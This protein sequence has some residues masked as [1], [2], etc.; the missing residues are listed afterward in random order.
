MADPNTPPESYTFQP[1][2]VDGKPIEVAPELATEVGAFAKTAKLSAEQAQA[3]YVRE[4]TRPK[5][6]APDAA[7]PPESYTFA[8]LKAADGKESDAP[9]D[10]VADVTAEAKAMGLTQAQAQKMLDRELKLRDE[11][12]GEVEK[13]LADLK[14]TWREAGMK[15]QVI[16]GEKFEENVSIA[17]RALKAFF[18][19][20]EKEA[21]KHPILD[22]P[23]V[24]R[25]LFKIGKLISQDGTFVP[26]GNAGGEVDPAKRLFP[27]M[28]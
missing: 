5:P 16:G 19:E 3:I 7:K 8:K 10:V 11:A 14:K 2:Q 13:Q 26:P 28:N 6:K 12:D 27:N 22:N 25:G 15:D 17:K 4:A 23:D 18:P 1:V 20:L 21:D 9:A 24:L